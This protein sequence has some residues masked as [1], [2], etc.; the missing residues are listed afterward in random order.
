[1]PPGGLLR[2]L[3]GRWASLGL[4]RQAPVTIRPSPFN[5]LV[6]AAG[7]GLKLRSQGNTLALKTQM[8][9]TCSWTSERPPFDPSI[10]LPT[11]ANAHQTPTNCALPGRSQTIHVY[12]KKYKT[13]IVTSIWGPLF[14]VSPKLLSNHSSVKHRLYLPGVNVPSAPPPS[15]PPRLGPSPGVGCDG[16]RSVPQRPGRASCGVWRNVSNNP[17]PGLAG[18]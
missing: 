6:A 9:T 15:S 4:R 13:Y 7:T 18:D 2:F 1:M 16:P 5:G 10:V 17:S 11:K 3:G 12:G 14:E 8:L